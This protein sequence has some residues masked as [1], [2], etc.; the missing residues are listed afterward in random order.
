MAKFYVVCDDDCR[1]EGMTR[2]QI[3]TAIEQAV[4]QGYVSD[5][6]GAV[7]TRIKELREGASTRLWVGTEAQFNALDPAPTVNR[8]FVRVGADGVLYLC[9][10]ESTSLIDMIYP[11]G[12]IYMSVNDISPANFFG[13]SWE[14]IQDR[15]LLA[16]GSTY[17]AGSTG[18]EATHKLTVDEMPNHNHGAKTENITLTAGGKNVPILS[19]NGTLFYGATGDMGGGKAHNNMPPYLSVYIWKRTA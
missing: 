15:F 4:E 3:L 7:F 8:S 1:Y 9:K 16:A 18:G 10:D 5:P 14:R 11:V 17:A 2:E 13:G 12:S 19:A 6:D